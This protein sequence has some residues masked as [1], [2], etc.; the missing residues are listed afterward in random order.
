M[1]NKIKRLLFIMSVLLTITVN[2]AL[3]Y[4]L[5]IIDDQ[6]SKITINKKPERVVS[7]VPGITEIIFKIGE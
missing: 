2:Q 3:A 7:L 1:K 4:P 6:G 5:T